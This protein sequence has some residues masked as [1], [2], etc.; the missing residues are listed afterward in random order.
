MQ[1]FQRETNVTLS[2]YCIMCRSC[3]RMCHTHRKQRIR[4]TSNLFTRTILFVASSKKKVNRRGCRGSYLHR[5]YSILMEIHPLPPRLHAASILSLVCLR[6]F[7]SPSTVCLCH[8]PYL[9]SISLFLLFL[10]PCSVFCQFFVLYR[11]IF[12]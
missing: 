7:F 5:V 2:C 1:N 4:A 11:R 12:T 8:I 9:L 6:S 10:F 3:I